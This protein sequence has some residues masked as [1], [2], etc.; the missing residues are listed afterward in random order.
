MYARCSAAALLFL[1]ALAVPLLAAEPKNVLI[2]R[3]ESAD[4]PGGSTLV[5]AIESSI[6]KASTSPIEFYV[7]TVDTGRFA[8]ATYE[9]RLSALLADKY[10]DNTRPYLFYGSG[11]PEDFRKAQLDLFNQ[12]KFDLNNLDEP[13]KSNLATF[14]NK[15]FA[16]DVRK[17]RIVSRISTVKPDVLVLSEED[18]Q[19]DF[20][21]GALQGAGLTEAVYLA[22][23]N[24]PDGSGV[25]FNAKKFKLLQQGSGVYDDTSARVYVW[26]ALETLSAPVRKVVVIGT[27]LERGPDEAPREEVRVKQLQSLKTKVLDTLGNTDG[28]R[29]AN[30]ILAGDF[31]AMPKGLAYNT[32]AQFLGFQEAFDALNAQR[33]AATSITLDRREYIDYVFTKGNTLVAAKSLVDGNAVTKYLKADRGIPNEQEPSDHIPVIF[34]YN[35]NFL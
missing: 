13:T 16:W 33:P 27:H 3:G 15:Y 21:K 7:E 17:T 25:Y 32:A 20:M 8:S 31:N 9:D 30:Y 4:L 24:K 22:R 34:D 6:H 1:T 18:H 11:K 14:Q 5:E 35:L 26:A 28:Y 2:V 23:P 29:D 19:T 10:A 12:A